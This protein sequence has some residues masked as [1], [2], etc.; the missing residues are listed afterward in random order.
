M[1]EATKGFHIKWDDG[2]ATWET[3]KHVHEFP[4]IAAAVEDYTSKAVG[5]RPPS[6]ATPLTHP[7]TH[8]HTCTAAPI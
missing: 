1:I 6:D 4:A 2:K 5:P 7:H 3:A 8:T